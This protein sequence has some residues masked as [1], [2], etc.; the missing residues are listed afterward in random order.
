MKFKGVFV[1]IV[2]RLKFD[3]LFEKIVNEEIDSVLKNLL[4]LYDEKISV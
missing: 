2:I 3:K 4:Y 1:V